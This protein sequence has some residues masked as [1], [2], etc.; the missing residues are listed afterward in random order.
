MNAIEER[1]QKIAEGLAAAGSAKHRKRQVLYREPDTRVV[2]TGKPAVQ[3][4]VV[5]FVELGH[6][7]SRCKKIE[8]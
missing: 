3:G 4:R 7:K 8:W 1:Q 6:D 5:G 2:G